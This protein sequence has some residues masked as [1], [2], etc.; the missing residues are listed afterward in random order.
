MTSFRMAAR[1]DETAKAAAS[2]PPIQAAPVAAAEPTSYP[3]TSPSASLSGDQ[4]GG[5]GLSL[6]RTLQH[7]HL[8]QC[9]LRCRPY[10]RLRRLRC[11]RP[12]RVRLIN[13]RRSAG[14][15]SDR[16]SQSIS[17]CP[18]P[19][20]QQQAWPPAGYGRQPGS[21]QPFDN[22][23]RGQRNEALD[24][25]LTKAYAKTRSPAVA[26]VTSMPVSD[27]RP[28]KVAPRA[29]VAGAVKRI[30]TT[31]VCTESIVEPG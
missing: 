1:G 11:R 21:Y 2:A 9:R 24:Q 5:D 7:G 20:G 3:V 6:D 30:Y 19:P 27:G 14:E 13:R 15:T 18:G 22:T 8:R 4:S 28:S 12:I 10:A 31:A 29:T 26:N 25:A 17:R 23:A 16:L